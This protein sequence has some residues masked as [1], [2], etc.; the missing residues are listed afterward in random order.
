[1]TAPPAHGSGAVRDAARPSAWAVAVAISATA[2]LAVLPLLL[3]GNS[4]GN[5]FNFHLLSWM[6]VARAWHSGLPWPRWVG[7]ANYGA[8]EP[9]LLFY[10]PASWFLGGLLGTVAPWAAAGP[11]FVLLALSGGGAAMYLLAREWS[12][13][14]SAMLAGCLYAA[15]PYALFS[16]YERS[17]FG[18]L[19][20][21]AVLPLLV[22]FALRRVSS[23]G[24]LA[25]AKLQG[26]RVLYQGATLVAPKTPQD[27]RAS[28]PGGRVPGLDSPFSAACLAAAI[29]AIWLCDVPAGLIAS[30]LLAFLALSTALLERKAGPVIRAAAGMVLGTGLA[31]FYLLPAIYERS[32]VQM[33]RAITPGMQ[34]QDSFLF[35]HTSNPYHDQVLRTASWILVA[36]I[37]LAAAAIWAA[38]RRR[39]GSRP[40]A[41]IA[42]AALLPLLFF[43]QLPA[44]NLV[45]K[46]APQLRFLQFPWR[47]LLV[48]GVTGSFFAALALDTRGI[49][50]N[51]RSSAG[52]LASSHSIWIRRAGVG[53]AVVAMVA[54]GQRFFFQP[55]DDEDAV[56]PRAA[57]FQSGPVAA[58]V[59][60][61]DEYTPQS[62]DNGAIQ[63]GLPFVRV[64]KSPQEDEVDDSAPDSENP[65]WKPAIRGTVLAKFTATE[66]NEEHWTIRIESAGNGYAVLRLMDY[67]AWRVTAN[68][69]P[70]H[71][72]P[73]RPDGLMT[74]PISAGSNTIDVRWEPTKDV[75]AGDAASAVF[76][77]I[78][79]GL[80]A[81][82][83][84]SK[85]MSRKGALSRQLS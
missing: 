11:L 57:A 13:K 41:A 83:W 75:F 81:R 50:R 80:I 42:L 46:Y 29:A 27:Q 45:W 48:I 44:S 64:F 53:I 15:N 67:P 26:A 33:A 38:F 51:R 82:E 49:A 36:E 9:R 16:A 58:G 70:I 73:Q 60:G 55:C 85:S 5:D 63:Q 22:L 56:A 28:A 68:G 52:G 37:V 76:L 62:A 2:L 59:E 10:P 32:W 79:L 35:G 18:E 21:G 69:G 61:T 77:V 39:I 31:A 7:E 1:M 3:R 6:E 40:R 17:A 74:I 8:G 20:A 43:L 47:W 34:V 66:F 72:R 19:L 84:R 24:A 54:I 23:S 65:V 78:L 12:G 71:A 14:E 4:C 30:Y 25:A